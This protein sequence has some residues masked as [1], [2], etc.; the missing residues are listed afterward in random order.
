MGSNTA[1]GANAIGLIGLVLAIV[2]GAA[3]MA[4][5]LAPG[6]SPQGQR[7]AA[8][9]AA[10]VILWATEAAPVGVT[11]L[12]ALL[13]QPLAGARPLTAA[14][15]GFASPVFFFVLAMFC[16]A[17]GLV[18]SGVDR[19]F[20]RW[21]LDR[22]GGDPSRTVLALM[23]GTATISTVMSDVPACAI[24]MAVGL[25]LLNDLGVTPGESRLGKAMMIG[26]PIASLIGGVATPAGSSINILGIHFIEQHGHVRIPFL[27]W[28]AIG[29]PMALVLTPLAWW[30][31]VRAFPPEIQTARASLGPVLPARLTPAEWKVLALLATMMTLWILG[32]WIPSLDVT[33]VA[34]GGAIAMFLPGIRL[35]SWK[36]ADR[37]IGWDILLMIGG[38]TSLGSATVETGLARWLVDSVLGGLGDWPALAVV[39]T[40]SAFTVVAHLV[41]TVGP[42]LAAVLIPPI[43][44]LAQTAGHHPALYGLPVAFTASCAFL[45]PL[46]PVL[47]LTYSRGYYR[48]TDML[49]PGII[50]SLVWIA[51]ITALVLGL[52]PV[53]G[54]F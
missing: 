3:V 49:A 2:V 31:L 38:V 4:A 44:V 47:L 41:L 26:I 7:L 52:G 29:V 9:F 30:V 20:A 17:A 1:T 42:V 28:M 50:L 10:V 18:G 16:L 14:F 53:S 45:L 23:V 43:V 51:V 40:V 15:A 21:L 6:L 5:P 11:A 12:L 32:T 13:L 19:R 8:I 24:F 46:D 25:R 33:M 35:V 36:D 22:A 34:L 48:M 54:L 39:A 37:A 27:T